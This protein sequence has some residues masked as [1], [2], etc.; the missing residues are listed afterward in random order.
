MGEADGHRF[1]ARVDIV[2]EIL[3][4]VD[5][6]VDHR[7]QDIGCDKAGC[8]RHG[9]CTERV[10]L[11]CSAAHEDRPGERE[12]ENQLRVVGQTFGEGIDG[13]QDR[14][15]DGVIGAFER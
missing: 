15:G 6:V 13:E 12:T 3:M 1:D 2:L 7:P 10:D 8:G 4:S 11:E 14:D 5:G 9:P